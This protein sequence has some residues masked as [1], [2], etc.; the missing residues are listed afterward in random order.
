MVVANVLGEI[1]WVLSNHLSPW[2][3]MS[4]EEGINIIVYAEVIM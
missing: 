2:I 4:S 1:Q 3:R